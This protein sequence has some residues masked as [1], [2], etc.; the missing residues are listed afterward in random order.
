MKLSALVEKSYKKMI[1]ELVNLTPPDRVK[2]ALGTS[3]KLNT[4][5][6]VFGVH[7]VY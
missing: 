7:K 2:K 1:G 3:L 4:L 5:F 6:G